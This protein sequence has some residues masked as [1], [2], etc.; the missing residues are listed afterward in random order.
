MK[1]TASVLVGLLLVVLWMGCTAEQADESTGSEHRATVAKTEGA[2]PFDLQPTLFSATD[3]VATPIRMAV[4]GD[5][6]VV[7]DA[8]ADTPL[9]VIR[10]E[11]AQYVA[12]LGGKG[13]GPGEFAGVWSLDVVS[14]DPA[15]LWAYDMTQ[16]R[17]TYVDLDAVLSGSSVL[18]DSMITMNV[19][20]NVLSP[21]WT[22]GNTYVS[23]GFLQEPGRL[24]VFDASGT[25]QDIVGEPLPN[26]KKTLQ[27]IV[28][29]AYQARMKPH[30]DRSKLALATFYADR[31][32]IYDAAGALRTT[33]RGPD[34]FDPIYTVGTMQGQ[35]VRQSTPDTR[36]GYVDLDATDRFIYALYSGRRTENWGPYGSRLHVF[37]WDGR[38]VGD[39]A[40]NTYAL[41]IAVSPDGATL[42]ASQHYPDLAIVQYD[43]TGLNL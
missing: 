24:A 28:Q 3:T 32:E 26:P 38:L 1:K 31:I 8:Y 22:T 9:H 18:G 34:P 36:N 41:G 27:W 14:H 39:V 4:A 33:A 13:E 17:L 20:F 6:L 29:H 7:Q 2:A 5:Y 15:Q 19:G 16:K 25:L 21:V 43:L 10:A 30:P 40:L 35:P 37:T 11:D 42:Y 23:P 12:T